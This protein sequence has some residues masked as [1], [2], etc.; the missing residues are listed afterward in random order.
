LAEPAQIGRDD[1]LGLGKL[2][3]ERP[4][5]V[6]GLSAAVQEDDGVASAGKFTQPA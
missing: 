6:T 5:H 2:G 1:G 3:N 4:P